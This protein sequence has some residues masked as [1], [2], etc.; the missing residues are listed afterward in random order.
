MPE[1]FGK[2]GKFALKSALGH[3]THNQND[4]IYAA[5]FGDEVPYSNGVRTTPDEVKNESTPFTL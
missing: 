2:S 4:C 1:K 5:T 3:G